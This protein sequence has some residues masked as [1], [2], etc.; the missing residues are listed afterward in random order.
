MSTEDAIHHIINIAEKQTKPKELEF[1]LIILLDIKSAFDNC[2][3]PHILKQLKRKRCPKNLYDII[4]SYLNDR[5]SIL[6]TGNITISKKLDKGCP[7]GSALGPGLWN[8]NYDNLL[9]I[10]TPK[11][12]EIMGFCD[13][14]KVLVFGKDIKQ[15]E[16]NANQILEKMCE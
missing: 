3:F 16:I 14:T 6:K 5:F 10:E 9:E 4:E 11:N 2:W 13:N 8:I 7:Q 1:L 12:S 15:I